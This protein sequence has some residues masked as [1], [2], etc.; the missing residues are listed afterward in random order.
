SRSPM[1]ENSAHPASR[2]AAGTI[3]GGRKSGRGCDGTSRDLEKPRHDDLNG[4]G[5]EVVGETRK[6]FRED[7]GFQLLDPR[8]VFVELHLD[9]LVEAAID[10]GKAFMHLKIADA[11]CFVRRKFAG[12]LATKQTAS[13]TGSKVPVASASLE[14]IDGMHQDESPF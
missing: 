1:T 5:C 2:E 11:A 8:G 9:N 13:A 4:I 12:W 14:R 10:G 7:S 3:Y 6:L